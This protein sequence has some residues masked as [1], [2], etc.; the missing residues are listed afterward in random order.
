M[1]PAIPE[2]GGS[3]LRSAGFDCA[4]SVLLKICLNNWA[5]RVVLNNLICT[6]AISAG[7][8]QGGILG[9]LRLNIYVNDLLNLVPEAQVFADGLAVSAERIS[10]RLADIVG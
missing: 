7:V 9:P 4:M 3:T 1:L 6:Q 8:P 2:V 10:G 5:P